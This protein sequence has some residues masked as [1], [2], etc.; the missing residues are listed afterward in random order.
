MDAGDLV[1]G[2]WPPSKI[3]KCE[4]D[5]SM[6]T[7]EVCKA[8]PFPATAKLLDLR[9]GIHSPLQYLRRAIRIRFG[10][11]LALS[12][13][14]ERYRLTHPLSRHGGQEAA[15]AF[16]IHGG[17]RLLLRGFRLQFVDHR[18]E[19]RIPVGFW[20]SVPVFQREV[21]FRMRLGYYL[22]KRQC[23]ARCDLD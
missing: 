21:G 12:H 10:S 22:A 2:T 18:R 1:A 6:V 3:C 5:S 11:H 4:A 17:L 19:Q 13:G 20:Q 8:W 7:D 23:L 14:C 9:G 16:Q 15:N